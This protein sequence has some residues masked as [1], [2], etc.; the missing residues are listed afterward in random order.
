MKNK[1]K[2]L[3]WNIIKVEGDTEHY[4]TEKYTFDKDCYEMF[5]IYSHNSGM[6]DIY[7]EY[8]DGYT[9]DYYS[10]KKLSPIEFIEMI[11][12]I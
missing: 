11:K 9:S 5:A 3:G 12:N 7:Y 2:E 10:N 8:P 4:S 1:M 6:T